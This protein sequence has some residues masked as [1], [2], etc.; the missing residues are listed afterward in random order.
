MSADSWR[1]RAAEK[2]AA[3]KS[4]AVSTARSAAGTASSAVVS[5]TGRAGTA[6]RSGAGMAG[7]AVSSAAGD[8]GIAARSLATVGGAKA[9]ALADSLAPLL[10]ARLQEIGV[11]AFPLDSPW[12]MG[13]GRLIGGMSGVPPQL[14]SMAG[15]LDRFG[16]ISISKEEIEFDGNRVAWRDVKAITFAPASEALLAIP[17]DEVAQRLT[18]ALPPIPGRA[19]LVRQS[20]DTLVA[21]CLAVKDASMS[22]DDV[23]VPVSVHYGRAKAKLLRPG[24]FAILLATAKP[25]ITSV[26]SQQAAEYGSKVTVNPPSRGATRAAALGN[27]VSQLRQRGNEIEQREELEHRESR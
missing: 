26:M 4:K 8:L 16:S 10:P 3:A 24:M 9:Q 15:A 20:M 2:A 19:W 17:A 5:A 6:A 25:E 18:A 23:Q 14:Q 7:S 12:G 11:P 27:V 21:I 1:E 13:L 22:G